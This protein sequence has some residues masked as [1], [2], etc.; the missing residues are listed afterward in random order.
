MS[1][2]LLLAFSVMTCSQLVSCM[3]E[4]GDADLDIDFYESGERPIV[5]IRVKPDE[6]WRFSVFGGEAPSR[7]LTIT[8][9]G[10]CDVRVRRRC[11]GCPQPIQPKIV[12]DRLAPGDSFVDIAEFGRFRGNAKGIVTLELM[13]TAERVRSPRPCA[14]PADAE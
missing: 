4:A 7:E 10:N 2:F 3:N 11:S 5:S 12:M 8:N 13:Y 1:Q 6:P 9:A 14:P